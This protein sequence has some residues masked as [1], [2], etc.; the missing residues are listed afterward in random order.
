M[1]FAITLLSSLA[2]FLALAQPA[3]AAI[4]VGDLVAVTAE[5]LIR[6]DGGAGQK[7]VPGAVVLVEQ[8]DANRFWVSGLTAGWVDASAVMELD[9]AIKHF[10][11]LAVKSPKDAA[12]L[13]AL[14]NVLRAR[15]KLEAALDNFCRAERITPDDALTLRWRA[16]LILSAQFPDEALADINA[17]VRLAPNDAAALLDRGAI[18]CSLG[19]SVDALR[20]YDA[21]LKLAP[22][23][24]AAHNGR[25]DVRADR[26]DLPGAIADYTEAARLDPY[27]ARALIGRADCYARQQREDLALA[28]LQT[29]IKLNPKSARA[30]LRLA[31]LELDA[32]SDKIRDT[33]KAIEHARKACDL[34]NWRWMEPAMTLAEAHAAAGDSSRAVEMRITAL[35]IGMAETSHIASWR[36]REHFEHCRILAAEREERAK[37]EAAVPPA[38]AE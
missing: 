34:S 38:P 27:D 10:A 11:D 25:G 14:A 22:Q 33:A 35:R 18:Y 24:A 28:D 7:V 3:P 20:D 9:A 23:S 17:A 5:T 37:E 15:G 31:R 13:R 19:Q 6:S 16:W 26:G 4:E 36:M 32:V 1:R 30:Y 29:A 12:S 21:A 8:V 2:L